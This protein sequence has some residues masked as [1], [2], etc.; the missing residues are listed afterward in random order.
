M[1][2][3]PGVRSHQPDKIDSARLVR[4][5]VI[6][7]TARLRFGY[8]RKLREKDWRRTVS[9]TV[10]EHRSADPSRRAAK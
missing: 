3:V 4:Q 5:S 2:A 10:V 6:E 8:Y 1:M 9:T 7:K